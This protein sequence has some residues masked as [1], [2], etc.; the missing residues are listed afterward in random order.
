MTGGILTDRLSISSSSDQGPLQI[1]RTNGSTSYFG[2][3]VNFD[4]I[5]RTNQRSSGRIKMNDNGGTVSIG[6]V[7]SIIGDDK[8]TVAGPIFST[9]LRTTQ[10]ESSGTLLKIKGGSSGTQII[11]NNSNLILEASSVGLTSFVNLGTINALNA[12]QTITN[13]NASG[14]ASQYLNAGGVSGQIYT[15]GGSMVIS[16]NTNHPMYFVH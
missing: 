7:A 8:L 5:L 11:D 13:T 10:V 2:Y 16:T 12:T 1:T 14:Y 4:I 6:N 3:G 15:W 9:T